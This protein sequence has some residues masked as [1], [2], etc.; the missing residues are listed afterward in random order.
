MTRAM[1]ASAFP[2]RTE[3]RSMRWFH[4]HVVPILMGVLA[5]GCGG[6][7]GGTN[8]DP[9]LIRVSGTYTTAATLGQSNC[10]TPPTIEQH[11]TTVSHVPGATA[12][13]LSHAGSVYTGTLAATGTFT[14]SPSIVTIGGT[15]YTVT[16]SGAFTTTTIEALVT[17]VAT[18]TLTCE[19]QVRWLGPK[20]GAPNVIP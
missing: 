16:L 4:S 8:P 11:P 6:G 18:G 15:T 1:R 14:T 7:G 3:E 10:A 20:Q 12:V 5:A 9:T 19:Y 17:I 2:L 13:N